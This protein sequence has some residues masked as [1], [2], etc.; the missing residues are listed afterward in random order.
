[1]HKYIFLILSLLIVNI[2]NADIYKWTAPNGSVHFSDTPQPG[3]EKITL[4]TTQTYA[5]AIPKYDASQAETDDNT[6]DETMREY[7][8]KITQPQA[9]A[10]LRNNQGYVSIVA[11]IKPTLKKGDKIQLIFDGQPLGLPQQNSSF[12]LND[13]N[14]GSHTVALQVVDADGK[15]ISTSDTVMFFVHRARVG[16]VHHRN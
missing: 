4:P 10:T 6:N 3:A 13:V 14:R 7:T 9:S 16:M 8:I 2:S 11:E 12:A 5:P 1:M 15:T